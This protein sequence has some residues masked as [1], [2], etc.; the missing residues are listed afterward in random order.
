MLSA[1]LVAGLVTLSASGQSITNYFNDGKDPSSTD[2]YPGAAG[3]GW[4]G[5]WTA[6]TTLTVGVY[7]TIVTNPPDGTPLQDGGNYLNWQVGGVANNASTLY[8]QLSGG[9]LSSGVITL[10]PPVDLFFR[11]YVIEFD[12]RHD[13]YITNSVRYSTLATA[14]GAGWTSQND[15]T[16]IQLA[17]NTGADVRNKVGFW[18]K[19]QSATT[20]TVPSL[21]PRTWSFFDGN[22]FGTAESQGLWVNSTNVPY[23]LNTV[24]H[25]KIEVDAIN[26]RYDGTVSNTV[27]GQS[28]STKANA[29]RSLRWHSAIQSGSDMVGTTLLGFISRQSRANVT[30]EHSMD[31]LII[32]QVPTNLW[33]PIITAVSPKKSGTFGPPFYQDTFFTAEPYFPSTSNLIFSAATYGTN[34]LPLSNAHLSL[35]GVDVSAGLTAPGTT[36]ADNNRTFVSTTPLTD[37]KVYTAVIAVADQTGRYSTNQFFFNTF[38]TN[39]MVI[40]EAENFNFDPAAVPC[41][42]VNQTDVQPDRY[43]QNWLYGGL[44]GISGLF[45]NSAGGASAAD[46]YYARRGV[47]GIDYHAVDTTGTGGN[48]RTCMAALTI[49]NESSQD[50][51]RP[52][53]FDIIGIRDNTF[54]RVG[55][56]LWLNYTHEWPKSNYVAYLRAAA[57]TTNFVYELSKVLETATSSYTNS[58]QESN[59]LAQFN[60]PRDISNIYYKD[61]PLVDNDGYTQ[62]LPLEGKTT[63]KLSVTKGDAAINQNSTFNNFVFIPVPDLVITNVVRSGANFSFEFNSVNNAHYTIQYK[64]NVTDVSWTTLTTKIGTGNGV[65]VTDPL[66]DENRLYR[67]V[68]P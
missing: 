29:G 8:R 36:D 34:T 54:R 21:L 50:S 27:T 31:N 53:P 12:Y 61:H 5:G 1:A 67:V 52:N 65:S 16:S 25:F 14:V 64:T 9:T 18:I 3:N 23:A 19:A 56:N 38:N 57:Q 32:Y 62:I 22:L 35:N 47:E 51:V 44:S 17:G 30:N 49:N 60:V 59:K 55:T 58:T 37:N 7:P 40:F 45:T 15:Y 4:F 41:D 39:S 26:H 2:A 42:A 28:F 66:G 24:F 6:V 20:S 63:L 10:A 46:T 48:F 43:I 11:P 68:S 33:P 13:A